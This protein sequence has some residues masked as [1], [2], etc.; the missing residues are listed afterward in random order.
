MNILLTN[1]DGI[2]S[3]GLRQIALK[4]QDRG[5]KVYVVAPDTEMSAKSHA[6]TVHQDM[7]L[8]KVEID[9]LNQIA[10]SLTGT[11]ADCVRVALSVLYK[12]IDAIFSGCNF[13]LNAGA[14]ILY[15]GTV[16]AC[17]EANIFNLPGV[18]ISAEVKRGECDFEKAAIL[19][20]NLYEKYRL[21]IDNK[22]IVL[23][24]NVPHHKEE[25]IKGI[26]VCEVGGVIFDEFIIEE[27]NDIS[28]VKLTGRHRTELTGNNDRAYLSQGYVTVSPINY[29][30]NDKELLKQFK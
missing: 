22:Q 21:E 14:D 11:P 12:D 26:K 28:L 20:V 25:D 5:H 1:D 8:K 17:I 24:I 2:H 23:N 19:G 7:E 3:E 9:G 27:K 13:G 10:Y 6:I 30:F 15:S 29:N 4:L 18:A 16:S